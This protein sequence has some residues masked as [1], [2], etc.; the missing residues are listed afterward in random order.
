MA[1]EICTL[2]ISIN[3]IFIFKI[4]HDLCLSD[5]KSKYAN[6][7]YIYDFIFDGIRN[8]A[9]SFIIFI[10]FVVEIFMTLTF[11]MGQG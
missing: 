4:V 5:V 11:K 9:L 6:Q 3:K 7:K 10:I 2:Y 1:L 8:F